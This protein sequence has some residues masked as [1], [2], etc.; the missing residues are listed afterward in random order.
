MRLLPLG[1]SPP[2][3]VRC[4]NSGVRCGP[5]RYRRVRVRTAAAPSGPSYLTAGNRNTAS[6][7]RP[8][9]QL[10]THHAVLVAPRQIIDR[11]R[12]Q[13]PELNPHSI[14]L[15]RFACRHAVS[16]AVLCP[17]RQAAQC[18]LEPGLSCVIAGLVTHTVHTPYFSSVLPVRL[19]LT[20][21]F[22][23]GCCHC[24]LV[25]RRIP[26]YVL[27]WLHRDC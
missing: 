26:N 18:L 3:H 17:Q 16:C 13:L 14:T 7:R 12:L 27:R 19:V 1:H 20:F 25:Q 4:S 8:G 24:C 15:R 5:S 22:S 6:K 10:Q 21:R 2:H 23:S 11:A 9:S